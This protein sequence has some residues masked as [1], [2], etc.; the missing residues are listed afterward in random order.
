MDSAQI[1]HELSSSRYDALRIAPTQA[2]NR[3]PRSFSETSPLHHQL[4]TLACPARTLARPMLSRSQSSY[5]KHLCNGPGQL[6]RRRFAACGCLFD[7]AHHRG[8]APQSPH[9]RRTPPPW[10]QRLRAAAH[11]LSLAKC[12]DTEH[13]LFFFRHFYL[14]CSRRREEADSLENSM[15]SAH[16]FGCNFRNALYFAGFNCCNTRHNASSRGTEAPE[17]LA[18]RN[19]SRNKLSNSS[20]MPFSK[21]SSVEAL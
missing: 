13:F 18:W 21:S 7:L 12:P 15:V 4:R 14:A 8:K 10:P 3:L 6:A 9:E 1:E 11:L 17:L 20:G 5:A 19:G 2:L 16:P